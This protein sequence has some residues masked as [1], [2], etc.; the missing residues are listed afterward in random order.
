ME[1]IK[2]KQGKYRYCKLKK[3]PW[4]HYLG[5]KYTFAH[6][7][8]RKIFSFYVLLTLIIFPK[9]IQSNFTL[10]MLLKTPEMTT[11]AVNYIRQYQLKFS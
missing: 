7:I 3:L 11:A 5:L 10:K 4:L 1:K 6:K 9:N 2:I 8:G